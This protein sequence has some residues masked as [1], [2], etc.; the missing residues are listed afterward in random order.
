MEVYF[1]LI[2]DGETLKSACETLKQADV[3]GFDT[4]T[5]ELDPYKG[6]I[7]L[8]QLSDGKDTKVIDLKH[9][10]E[11]GDLKTLPELAPLRDLLAAPKPVKIAHNAKF[12]AKWVK[13]HLGVDLGGVFDTLLASQLIAAGD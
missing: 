1:Q 3:L 12:D 7:R 4:E 9:F 5:T 10:A 11:I 6:I 13:H 2:T 8:V